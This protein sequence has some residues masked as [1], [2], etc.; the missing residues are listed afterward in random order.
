MI[1]NLTKTQEAQIP[2]YVEKFLKLAEKPTNRKA[3]TKAIQNFYEFSGHKKPIVIFGESPLQTIN[4]VAMCKILFKDKL[5]EKEPQLDTQLY[6]QLDT[7]LRTQLENINNDWWLIVWWLVWA[8]WYEFGKYI[9]VQ[10]DE[11]KYKIFMDLVTNISFLVPYEGIVFISENPKILWEDKRLHSIEK[12]AV[13][14]ADGYGLYAI[15]GVRFEKE[16]WEKVRKDLMSPKEVFAIENT[17]QRR[18]AYE[19]M[20]KKKMLNLDHSILDEVKDDGYGYPMKLISVKVDGLKEPLK[21]LNC[22]CPTT[23]REY[24]LKTI[25]N[26]CI[27]AKNRSFGEED[28]KWLGEY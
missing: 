18:I 1:K 17:E 16:L 10:F 27:A 4:M 8:G 19:L 5:I 2:K 24:H 28:I 12:P 26:T 13:E 23:G 11:K 6:D 7:Q 14:Y 9:G 15:K 3:A 21:L 25:Q 20:D 22:F